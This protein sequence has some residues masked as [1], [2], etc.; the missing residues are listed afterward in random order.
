M[1]KVSEVR[2]DGS[3]V[4]F[5]TIPAPNSQA[6]SLPEGNWVDPDGQG[7]IYYPSRDR[8]ELGQHLRELR[9]ARNRAQEQAI[10]QKV[11]SRVR[12]EL[13][14]ITEQ[15]DREI[16]YLGQYA[17]SE[18]SLRA[19]E[20]L[21]AGRAAKYANKRLPH[22]VVWGERIKT[23]TA[24][25][26]FLIIAVYLVMAIIGSGDSKKGACEYDV[27]PNGQAIPVNCVDDEP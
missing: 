23:G 4:E 27:G 17:A 9:A 25:I 13:V 12:A 1:P 20:A 15:Y 18:E 11:G 19:R 8:H 24:W 7:K 21:E 10:S 22:K 6:P 16:A 3:T 2:A 5:W 14:K 26:I